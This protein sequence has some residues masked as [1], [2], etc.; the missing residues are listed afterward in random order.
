MMKN[1]TLLTLALA[2]GVVTLPALA[3][4]R[5]PLS[6]EAIASHQAAN[7]SILLA[8][9]RAAHPATAGSATSATAKVMGTHTQPGTPGP[10]EFRAYPPSCAADPLP[11]KASGPPY[12]ASVPLY[13][14]DPNNPQS[15]VIEVATVTVW[16]I[17]CSSSGVQQTYNPNGL[18]NAITLVRIDRHDDSITAHV[19]RFPL[20]QA[21]QGTID[22]TV[23]G[24]RNPAS[25]VRAA[26]EPN[27]VVSEAPYDSPVVTSTTY[28]L[29]NYPYQGSGYF[30][31]SDAFTLRIDPFI[32]GVAPIDILVPDYVPTQATYPDAS[33]DLPI[34][35][36]MSSAWYSP[37]H[38]GEGLVVQLL[39]NPDGVTHTVFAAWYTYDALGLPF[40]LIAQGVVN[41]GDRTL[42]NAPVYYF[43]GGGF[44][45][46]FGAA[47]DIHPWGTMSMSFPDCNSIHF[48][49]SGQ[50]DAQ[51]G[52]PAGSGTR[53]WTRLANVNGLTCE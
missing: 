13:A 43:T 28:V 2:A 29:E 31:F 26:V 4:M 46:N 1:L 14:T 12:S 8:H 7:P 21:K 27:T 42:L 24:G 38:S 9:T 5:V 48:T 3:D 45:G 35:G 18:P 49:Y 39:D 47:A 53:D 40:W 32:S 16:R 25:F 19:P 36:Y 6:A 50:T 41:P 34:S 23:A 22:F 30:A 44:A 51:T 52:G 11:D 33:R 15:A 37:A 10:N 20:L 17:A